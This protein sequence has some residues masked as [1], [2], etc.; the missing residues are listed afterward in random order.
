ML[1]DTEGLTLGLIE[2]EILVLG[3]CDRETDGEMDGETLAPPIEGDAEGETEGERLGLL[4]G[5]IEGLTE[6]E[7]DGEVEGLM[8]GEKEPD[9]P[10]TRKLSTVAPSSSANIPGFPI[11]LKEESVTLIL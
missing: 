7:T 2:G 3:D 9:V 8:L 6:T 11:A 1:N 4:L 5:E 10:S